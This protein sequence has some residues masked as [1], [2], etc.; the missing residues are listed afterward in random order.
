M[1]GNST[2]AGRSVT[3]KVIAILSN[4]HAPGAYS[5]TEIARLSGLPIS[6]THRLTNEL[7]IWG[8]LERTDGGIYRVGMQL[9]S[10]REPGRR[11]PPNLHERARLV[12]E[13]LAVAAGCASCGWASCRMA[14]SRTS[15][16]GR[17]PA[18][19][20]P[21][22]RPTCRCTRPRW[23]RRC[24]RSRRQTLVD[25][26][27]ERGLSRYTPLT[28]TRPDGLRRALSVTR[29]TRVAVARREL[30]RRTSGWPCRC[31]AVGGG[32]GRARAGLRDGAG[33]ADAAP[34]VIVAGRGSDP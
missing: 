12:L 33:P 2:E 30:E 13:D 29:L 10:D 11:A 20:V 21:S 3:S 1:A 9:R 34:P 16:R 6:T 27:I 17:R 25:Q 23:A 18:L 5:L 7:V 19:L 28:I 22:G 15:R 26:V 31:S 4:V 32:G 8:M 14:R 24:W